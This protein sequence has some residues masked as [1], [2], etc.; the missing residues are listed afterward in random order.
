[1]IVSRSDG[2]KGKLF[3]QV[4]GTAI[5]TQL[6]LTANT[7]AYVLDG[8]SYD[9][10]QLY[11]WSASKADTPLDPSTVVES[12][13]V[14]SGSGYPADY[15]YEIDYVR[16]IAIF[17]TVMGASAV[18][19]T[20]AT[21]ST[22]YA[23]PKWVSVGDTSEFNLNADLALIDGGSPQNMTWKK[24]AL[25]ER[26]WGLDGTAYFQNN[27]WWNLTGGLNDLNGLLIKAYPAYQ[28]STEYWI[29]HCMATKIGVK[30]AKGNFIEQA[31][32]FSGVGPLVKEAS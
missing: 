17:D 32:S 26:S 9:A 20:A 4:G 18:V 5:T 8:I 28:K 7:T 15:G 25:G 21:S 1:M 23:T 2:K 22:G 24:S 16:G 11:F 13:L 27:R 12:T 3:V 31:F 30:V 10:Y 29:G 19:K 6:T 14:I